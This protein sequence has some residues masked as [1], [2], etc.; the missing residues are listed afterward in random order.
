MGG[1][2]STNDIV[3]G[4]A[5]MFGSMLLML[6]LNIVF[7]KMLLSAM[8]RVP[9]GAALL[10][11]LVLI[12]ALAK[13][14]RKIDSHIGKIG[15]NPAA[16]GSELRS[17]LPG[18]L[19][20]AALKT[21][22]TAVTRRA[23]GGQTG[24]PRGGQTGGGGQ[25]GA[26]GGGQ[27]GGGRNGGGRNGGGSPDYKNHER[28]YNGGSAAAESGNRPTPAAQ[29]YHAQRES[30][31]GSLGDNPVSAGTA[32]TGAKG[33]P[34]GAK[35][36]QRGAIDRD[37]SGFSRALARDAA[38]AHDG[39]RIEKTGARLENKQNLENPQEKGAATVNPPSVGR[40]TDA[41]GKRG[42]ARVVSL[43]GENRLRRAES[44]QSS[45]ISRQSKTLKLGETAPTG[46]QGAPLGAK[47]S[48]Q[49]LSAPAA[50]K[51]GDAGVKPVLEKGG[52]ENVMKPP[53]VG[54]GSSQPSTVSSQAKTIA[55]PKSGGTATQGTN[56]PAQARPPQNA[57][58]GAS[59]PAPAAPVVP[60]GNTSRPIREKG[61]FSHEPTRYEPGGQ[62]RENGANRPSG[63]GGGSKRRGGRGRP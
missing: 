45:E 52:G 40:K 36:A 12:V 39:E 59:R 50:P 5:R 61:G 26:P 34:Q 8:A 48:P 11:W 47:G 18:M 25:S 23:V 2:K 44:I 43:G 30:A 49:A 21:A 57:P 35:G 54:R 56:R 33:S 58:L 1:S 14:A 37:T 29:G 38:T 7:F 9:E 32:P 63:D 41:D 60:Q 20:Y 31:Y 62:R 15:L 17:G 46:A 4:W 42:G 13:V 16:T 27:T 55:T 19:V 3:R 22:T 51:S 6:V 53:T 28:W 10:P 24:A